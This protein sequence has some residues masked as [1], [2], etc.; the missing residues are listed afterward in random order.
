MSKNKRLR[1]IQEF[2]HQRWK[3][4]ILSAFIILAPF[5]AGARVPRELWVG[6]YLLI[7]VFI[8]PL[9][10]G[11]IVMKVIN[12]LRAES[13]RIDSFIAVFVSG[14]GVTMLMLLAG[15]FIHELLL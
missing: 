13:K 15:Y 7:A 10:M 3:I 6:F 2:L 4:L 9:L 1:R 5:I 12:S 11:A 8:A 14:W